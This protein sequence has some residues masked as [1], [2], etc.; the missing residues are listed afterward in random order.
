MLKPCLFLG[1]IL[2][3]VI[4]MG[5]VGTVLGAEEEE[6]EVGFSPEVVAGYIHA[7]IAADRAS[8]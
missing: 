5:S 1:I 3:L 7:V 6:S 4:A 2:A 8:H